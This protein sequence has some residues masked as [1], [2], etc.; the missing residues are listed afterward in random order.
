MTQKK[1]S[2]VG[3]KAYC[4]CKRATK[5]SSILWRK[6][7][8]ICRMERPSYKESRHHHLDHQ[9]LSMMLQQSS[10]LMIVTEFFIIT[11]FTASGNATPAL[12]PPAPKGL[13][14][15]PVSCCAF[16]RIK[17]NQHFLKRTAGITGD[18]MTPPFLALPLCQCPVH[19]FAARNHRYFLSCLLTDRIYPL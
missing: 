9:H 19:Y 1:N 8:I 15:A 14:A 2:M 4:R 7:E 17:Q 13:T 16:L 18:W 5:R 3:I 10:L 6:R 11:L 12:I